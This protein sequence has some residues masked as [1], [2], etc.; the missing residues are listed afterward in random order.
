MGRERDTKP[1]RLLNT[2]NKQRVEGGGGGEW[3][4]VVMEEGTCGKEHWVLYGN[5]F[6]NKQLKKKMWCVYM[7]IHTHNRVIQGNEKE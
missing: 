5:Q 6:D 4:V 3:E 2:D 7:Y 1:E